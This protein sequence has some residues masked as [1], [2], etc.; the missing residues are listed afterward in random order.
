MPDG[1]EANWSVLHYFVEDGRR[2]VFYRKGKP[3]NP[4]TRQRPKK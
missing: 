1:A 4:A 3:L 2:D